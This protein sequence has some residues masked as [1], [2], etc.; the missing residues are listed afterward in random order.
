MKCISCWRMTPVL[1]SC[2]FHVAGAEMANCCF[3]CFFFFLRYH[4]PIKQRNFTY[5]KSNQA[6]LYHTPLFICK[7][8]QMMASTQVFAQKSP[9]DSALNLMTVHVDG[10]GAQISLHLPFLS[11][12]NSLI[13]IILF[14]TSCICVGSIWIFLVMPIRPI[15]FYWTE[16]GGG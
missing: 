6:E 5:C 7:T 10:W 13:I 4:L 8:T 3:S 1:I 16:M 12:W 2:V 14:V 9:N 11:K 15:E